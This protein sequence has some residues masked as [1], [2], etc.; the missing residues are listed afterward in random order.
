MRYRRRR[1][2]LQGDD[3][4]AIHPAP[5]GDGLENDQARLVGQTLRYPF[6]L[7]PVH[8][9]QASL[10][11]FPCSGH[12]ASLDERAAKLDASKRLD[13][14]L[15]LEASK[16]RFW[17][18]FERHVRNSKPIG[19]EADMKRFEGKVAVVTGGNSG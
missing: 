16:R 5:F 6:N 12:P 14:H 19:A 15:N 13:V 7:C 11:D 10:T 18:L 9:F 3:F 4:A 17:R 1:N 8:H 2:T